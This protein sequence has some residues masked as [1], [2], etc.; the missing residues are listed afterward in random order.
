MKPKL[1]LL[2]IGNED[3][4][5]DIA[6]EMAKTGIKNL[7]GKGIEIECDLV[8][9]SDA[10]SSQN[11]AKKLS[12]DDI[13]GVI[14]FIG[15]WMES[16][17]A[18]SA[19]RMIEHLPFILWGFPMFL[20]KEGERDQTGSLV[21]YAV[22]KG[23]LD[24]VKYNYKGILGSVDDYETINKIISFGKAAS[25]Y[26]RLKEA[27]IGLFG[28]TSLFM[29]PGTFDHLILRKIIGPEVIHFDTEKI[30]KDLNKIKKDEL[31]NEIK[32]LKRK[33]KIGPNVTDEMLRTA[34]G[35]YLSLMNIVN[36]YKLNAT[37]V[38]CQYE[39]SK[40]FGMT[41][42]LPVSLLNDEKIVSGCEGDMITT[43]S[44]LILNYLTDQVI[45][46]GDITDVKDN[47]I[48]LTSCGMIP[49]KLADPEKEIVI[50]NFSLLF[51][52]LRE[53]EKGF[54]KG[55]SDELFKG[56]MNSV[57]LK[58]GK[59]TYMRL[60]E[61]IG[62]YHMLYGTG[63]GLKTDL[64]QGVMPGLEVQIDGNIDD[65]TDNFPSQHLAICY[66]DVS[67]ELLDLCNILKIGSKRI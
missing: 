40:D 66:G 19:V 34:I 41:P 67:K 12:K 20:N 4:Q 45:Y 52:Y 48:W 50:N 53:K 1:G 5:N 36:N 63:E 59:V 15:T 17:I 11:A 61:D 38:K 58:P 51:K 39:L 35:M 60:V 65:L 55:W 6:V 26:Q 49:Y 9:Y 3:M 21:G 31:E 46:Y 33:A 57:T 47:K 64:R 42:C 29:Y 18:M 14:I 7:E 10:I 8:P 62:N 25:T 22:F 30:V 16:N 24:R 32:K 37:T 28:Y 43:V 44:M 56:L 23:A 27:R 54:S 2:I 13:D